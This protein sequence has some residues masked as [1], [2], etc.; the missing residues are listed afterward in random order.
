MKRQSIED[1][2]GSEEP[3]DETE[4]GEWK[5][6]L[7]AQHSENYDHGIQSHHLM[8]NRWGNETVREIIFLGSKITADG[9][10]S[11]EIFLKNASFLEEKLW[12][13]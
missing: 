1:F 5:S 7:K 6:W 12:P 10:F 9:D 11:H 8:A 13:T 4:R 3:L 2:K